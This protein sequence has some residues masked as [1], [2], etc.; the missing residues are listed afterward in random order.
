MKSGDA[1]FWGRLKKKWK[2]KKLPKNIFR[3]TVDVHKEQ[4]NFKCYHGLHS[5]RG[6][7][8]LEGNM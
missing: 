4:G 6:F 8:F 2:K 1:T 7:N 3:L 5:N